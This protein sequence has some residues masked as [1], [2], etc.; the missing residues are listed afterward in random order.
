MNSHILDM[1][2][3]CKQKVIYDSN[4][5]IRSLEKE[6]KISVKLLKSLSEINSN[7]KRLMHELYERNL[8]DKEHLLLSMST[9][10]DD[11]L[12]IFQAFKTPVSKGQFG[13]KYLH[14]ILQKQFPMAEI[15]DTTHTPHSG[16][17]IV[18]V[19][20]INVMIEMKNKNTII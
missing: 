4:K 6:L 7:E 11:M 1:L 8:Q 19:N 17:I 15:R 3:R 13:E 16:N 18:S 5:R 10:L 20:G 2:K 9:C 12:S 14:S